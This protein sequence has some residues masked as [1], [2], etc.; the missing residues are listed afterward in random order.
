MRLVVVQGPGT[1]GAKGLC[2][3]IHDL[4]LS[5]YVAARDKDRRFCRVAVAKGLVE[6]AVLL[7]R[8]PTLPVDDAARARIE[9]LVRADVVAAQTTLRH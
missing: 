3:E 4:L 1:R 6:P 5:K 7:E 8:V 9:A 2:L